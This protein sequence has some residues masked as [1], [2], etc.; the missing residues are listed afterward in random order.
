MKMQL[1]LAKLQAIGS[2][3]VDT[4]VV[5]E[6]N[7]ADLSPLQEAYKK[8]F[9]GQVKEAGFDVSPFEGTEEQM[10]AFFKNIK[11]RWA[12]RKRE[13]AQEGITKAEG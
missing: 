8:F 9:E 1:N 5:L 4:A 2:D 10:I 6:S 13:L 7:S 12:T 11:Q 3:A